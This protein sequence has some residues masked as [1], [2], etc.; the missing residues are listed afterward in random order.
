MD[1]VQVARVR[2]SVEDRSESP[3]GKPLVAILMGSRSDWETVKAA[4]DT[5]QALGVAA[6]A[7]VLSAHRA[8]GPLHQ[9][10]EASP[11]KVFICAAGGAAHLAGVVASLTTRP[12]IALPIAGKLL[13]GLDSLLAMV[14]MPKGVPVATVAINGAANAGLLAAQILAVADPALAK[15][16]ADHRAAEMQKVLAEKLE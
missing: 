7:K 8:P 6:E 14:Q 13:D 15:R 10:V 2:S 3:S 16:L 9:Y 4:R 11:A 1:K 5:L 12:V